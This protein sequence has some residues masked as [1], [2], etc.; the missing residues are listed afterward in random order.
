MKSGIDP[1]GAGAGAIYLGIASV[2]KSRILRRGWPAGTKIPT[3]E[4]LSQEFGVAR[5]TARQAL[6]VLVN[7]NLISSRRG[8]GTYVVYEGPLVS[9]VSGSILEATSPAPAKHGIEILALEDRDLLPEEMKV[10]GKAAP[11]YKRISKVHSL[12]G[13][14]YGFFEVFIASDI[15]KRF[16]KGAEKK[17][18]LAWLMRELGV[19]VTISHER[20]TIHPADLEEA[21]HL[22]CQLAQPV[23]RLNR[24]ML[25]EEGR[26]VYAAYNSYRG[27]LFLQERK[28]T[29]GSLSDSEKS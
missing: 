23:A 12:E 29:V 17:Q 8:R 27:D 25:N 1:S 18:K 21:R 19:K 10:E 22:R 9:N 14:P 20:L 3:I 15:F 7:E 4:E 11:K 28:V 24:I 16:P 13:V 6:H 2:M 26:V 5:E